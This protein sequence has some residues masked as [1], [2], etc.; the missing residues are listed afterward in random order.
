MSS[1]GSNSSSRAKSAAS[2]TVARNRSHPR[3]L[4]QRFRQIFPADKHIGLGC[5]PFNGKRRVRGPFPLVTG[6]GLPRQQSRAFRNVLDTHRAVAVRDG[7][8]APVVHGLNRFG[9]LQKDQ[10]NP[11]LRIP[12]S[13]S[14][15]GE[16]RHEKPVAGPELRFNPAAFQEGEGMGAPDP[17]HPPHLEEFHGGRVGSGLPVGVE[18]VHALDAPR[19]VGIGDSVA[20]VYDYG[21][22]VW[23]WSLDGHPV[24]W[25]SAW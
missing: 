2:S 22:H 11:R 15:K 5:S 18:G 8:S 25:A 24:L 14:F 13:S 17:L 20:Q 10:R 1:K 12:K 4:G 3:Q 21:A 7:Q 6:I 23:S 9:I 19:E 16:A